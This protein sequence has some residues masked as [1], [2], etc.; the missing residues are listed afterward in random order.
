MELSLDCSVTNPVPDA[1]LLY[2]YSSTFVFS[3]FPICWKLENVRKK[4]DEF[5]LHHQQV[6]TDKDLEKYK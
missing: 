3:K 5:K 4:S 1:T 2:F 6:Q